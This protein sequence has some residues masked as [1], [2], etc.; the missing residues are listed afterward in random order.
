MTCELQVLN[1][2]LSCLLFTKFFSFFH[3]DL[4]LF[5]NLRLLSK[6][7][8]KGNAPQQGDTGERHVHVSLP[9]QKSPFE[10]SQKEKMINKRVNGLTHKATEVQRVSQI[11]QS[12]GFEKTVNGICEPQKEK[13]TNSNF[14]QGSFLT[15]DK[16]GNWTPYTTVADQRSS[17]FDLRQMIGSGRNASS[18]TTVSQSFG[19]H[20]KN[21]ADDNE[22]DSMSIHAEDD[23]ELDYNEDLN[24]L[25]KHFEA[26]KYILLSNFYF[27]S[28][29]ISFHLNRLE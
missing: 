5:L 25:G 28:I 24:E 7:T 26:T 27:F 18:H 11:V 6:R 12:K 10:E 19:H 16:S 2:L 23:L 20:E 21:T 15:N 3:V 14:S 13:F 22:M 9:H 29:L 8:L 1:A 4:Y 17:P